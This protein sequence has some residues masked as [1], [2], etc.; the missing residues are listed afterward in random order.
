[1]ND[2]TGINLTA[3]PEAIQ[4]RKDAVTVKVRFATSPGV[5]QTLEGRVRY[6]AGD[7]LVT[8]TSDQD[9]WPV[10]RDTFFR[11]YAPEAPTIAG[12]DGCYVK[13]PVI[14][15]ALR[16]NEPFQVR[17]RRGRGKLVGKPGDWL[18]QYAPGQHGIVSADVFEQT[19]SLFP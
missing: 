11:T 17:M 18:V 8:G 6:R 4:V 9:C 1:M 7:A 16:L 12:E 2:L 3:H 15:H 19:Y 14:V 13:C 10:V 5:V